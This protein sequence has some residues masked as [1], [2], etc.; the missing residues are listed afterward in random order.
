MIII[1]I[2]MLLLGAVLIWRF[3]SFSMCPIETEQVL[4]TEITEIYA[5]KSYGN[6]YLVKT[7]IGYIMIDAGLDISKTK[8]SL[9]DLG[10]NTSDVKFIFLTH[11]DGDHTA[12]LPLFSN[13]TIYMSKDELPLINGTV[14]RTIL[15]G[16]RMPSSINIADIILL[17]N[18][19]ELI[20][21]RIKIK[22][23]AAPGHTTGSMMYLVNN[24][25]LFTGDV[26]KI[27]SGNMD[28][29]PYSMNVVQSKK[30]IEQIKETVSN[31]KIVLTSHY[32]ILE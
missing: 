1:V 16:N 12:A 25:Y 8:I 11:S 23:I 19:Q 29:H 5:I 20:F 6:I 32:G 30:T 31:S 9:K 21:N 26:F 27:K 3:P 18:E 4:N 22:C 7:D 13:A 28:V 2:F 24:Q 10:I 15:G 14:K 17:S